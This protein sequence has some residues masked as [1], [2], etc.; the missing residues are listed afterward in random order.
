MATETNDIAGLEDVAKGT[1][2]IADA[3][4][5]VALDVSTLDFEPW[6]PDLL[7]SQMSVY[8]DVIKS[9]YMIDKIQDLLT[10][11]TENQNVIT[12]KTMIGGLLGSEPDLNFKVALGQVGKLLA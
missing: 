3:N 11:L 12:A 1:E 6:N 10:K 4:Q 5:G 7:L 9:I 2:L 8:K